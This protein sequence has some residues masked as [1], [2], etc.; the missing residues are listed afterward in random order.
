MSLLFSSHRRVNQWLNQLLNHWFAKTEINANVDYC[1][2]TLISSSHWCCVLFNS[3]PHLPLSSL[4]SFFSRP[5]L[6]LLL[7]SFPVSSSFSWSSP[8]LLWYKFLDIFSVDIPIG[9]GHSYWRFPLP[10]LWQSF[11]FIFL[12]VWNLLGVCSDGCLRIYDA[13]HKSWD[14]KWPDWT[15]YCEFFSFFFSFMSVN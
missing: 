9:R 14:N 13:H 7:P 4:P 10:L 15:Q 3:L 8:C 5:F 2:L 12:Q 1:S 11:W 6:T